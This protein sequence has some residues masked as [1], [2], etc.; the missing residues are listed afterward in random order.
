MARRWIDYTDRLGSDACIPVDGR[1]SMEN[2][3]KV[4]TAHAQR[5]RFIYSD[6]TRTYQVIQGSS[7]LNAKPVTQPR[8]IQIDRSG[9]PPKGTK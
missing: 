8:T 1:L 9:D 2:V 5:L 7:L 6:N 3:H 4:A